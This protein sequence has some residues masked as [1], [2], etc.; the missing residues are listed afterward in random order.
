[1]DRQPATED[2]API[3]RQVHQQTPPGGAFA[4]YRAGIDP[5]YKEQ[6]PRL[7]RPWLVVAL[8]ASLLG[9]ALGFA[10]WVAYQ[11]RL[12]QPAT[13][14]GIESDGLV[15]VFAMAIAIVALV[16][17]FRRG[18]GDGD[19]EML[20]AWTASLV[21]VIA[22]GMTLMYIE[23]FPI[24]DYRDPSKIRAA[25]GIWAALAATGVATVSAFRLWWS[26]R[27]Y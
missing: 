12:E 5:A 20:I 27:G 16:V 22:V 26:L 13:R 17:G 15:L 6:L 14:P 25:W 10:P 8:S 24:D 9:M 23:S 4:S 18:P 3:D 2:R 21:G 7:S 11:N 19:I 1:M